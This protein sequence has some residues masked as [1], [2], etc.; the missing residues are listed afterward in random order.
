EPME[1]P[2]FHKTRDGKRIPQRLSE[3]SKI[4]EALRGF[5]NV[6][7]VYTEDKYRT[8]VAEAATKVLG[9]LPYSAR[10]SY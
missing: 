4:F 6:I 10:I 5:I 7:R 3:I 2:V 1:I 9:E 8:E